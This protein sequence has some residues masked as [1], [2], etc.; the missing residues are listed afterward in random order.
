MS[1]AGSSSSIALSWFIIL[2]RFA[3][4]SK[5]VLALVFMKAG[6][7]TAFFITFLSGD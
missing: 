1:V 6:E 5:I 3:C 4:S 7:L 2:L